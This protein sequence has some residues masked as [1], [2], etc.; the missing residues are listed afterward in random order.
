[1][2]PEAAMD[3]IYSAK[4]DIWSCGIIM[5]ILFCGFP[6]FLGKNDKEITER[7][8]TAKLEFSQNAWEQVSAQ[9]KNLITKMLSKE[10][11]DRPTAAECLTDQWFHQL[12]TKM[13]MEAYKK[14]ENE[15]ILK[16]I[17]QFNG[18]LKMQQAAMAFI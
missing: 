8:A 1:M 4:S 10:P 6:P 13:G 16:N 3:N 17:K 11:D 9:A 15:A 2:A 12:R 7:A 5:H 18:A 14:S